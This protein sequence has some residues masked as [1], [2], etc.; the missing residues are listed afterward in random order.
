MTG[1]YEHIIGIN[2][3]TMIL[4]GAGKVMQ[5]DESLMAKIN[6]T[7]GHNNLAGNYK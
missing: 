1:F 6:Y 7:R 3:Y 4:E 5:I 2:K